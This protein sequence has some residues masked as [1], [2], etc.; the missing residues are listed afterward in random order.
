MVETSRPRDRSDFRVAIFCALPREADAVFLLFDHFWDE[1]ESSYGRAEGDPNHYTN[2]RIGQHDVVLAHL[3]GMGTQ[4]AAAAAASLRTSYT[5]LKLLCLV[6][7]CG[8]VPKIDGVDAFLGDVVISK[9]IIQYDYGRQ[10]PGRFA[11]KETTEDSLGRLNKDIRGLL[12][13]FETDREKALMEDKAAKYL[14]DMQNRKKQSGPRRLNG[15]RKYRNPGLGKDRLYKTDYIHKHHKEC[16]ECRQGPCEVATQ[17]SCSDLGCR[18]SKLVSRS[19]PSD[20]ND[21]NYKPAIFIGRVGSGSTVMKSGEDR[22]RIAKEHGII[23]FEME[24][25]GVWDEA[26]CLI[27]KGICDYADSHKDKRWQDFAAATAASVMKAILDRYAASD[28]FRLSSSPLS[29]RESPHCHTIPYIRNHDVVKRQLEVE[30]LLQLLSNS[31]AY[32]VAALWGLGGSGKTHIALEY[33]YQRW[34]ARDCSIFWVHADTEATFVRDYKTVARKL[35]LD[36]LDND[37]N[38]LEAVR[39]RIESLEN[40]LLVIDNAD[41]ITVFLPGQ[42]NEMTTNLLRYIPQAAGKS[43]TVLWTSRDERIV[44]IAGPDRAVEIS[45]MTEA[46]A[47]K[48]L[49]KKWNKDSGTKRNKKIAKLLEE[50]GCLALA[51]SQAGA[52]MRRTQTGVDEYLS[53]LSKDK[54]RWIL[55]KASETAESQRTPGVPNSVL[56]TWH[57]S[58]E[59][60]QKENHLAYH[61][62]NVLAYVNNQNISTRMMA[63]F[64]KSY[65]ESLPVDYKKK[66]LENDPVV[67]DD[68]D[69]DGQDI[70]I[71][72]ALARLKEYSF[73]QTHWDGKK[74][75]SYKM[76]KLVQ[77]A[78]RFGLSAGLMLDELRSGTSNKG[79]Q[80]YAAIAL[81]VMLRLF[82]GNKSGM[83]QQSEKYFDHAIRAAEWAEIS[84]VPICAARLLERLCDFIWCR[85]HGLQARRL[86]MLEK[87]LG[88]YRQAFGERDTYTLQ[89]MCLLAEGHFYHGAKE[90]GKDMTDQVYTLQQEVFG[91]TSRETV[92]TLLLKAKILSK[93]RRSEE[94][95]QLL[96]QA[97]D[98]CR[99]GGKENSYAAAMILQRRAQLSKNKGDYWKAAD[100]A[101]S[102]L[103]IYKKKLAGETTRAITCMGILVEAYTQI[104]RYGEAVS[105]GETALDMVKAKWGSKHM[106]TN[107]IMHKLALSYFQLG[108]YA[109]AEALAKEAV[110]LAQD[111][112]G[113]P[114]HMMRQSKR[115]LAEMPECIERQENGEPRQQQLSDQFAAGLK[116]LD[117][118]YEPEP[119]SSSS[120]VVTKALASVNV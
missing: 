85:S 12:A 97:M 32:Q 63:E 21:D 114:R 31:T 80:Y 62:L 38:I 83:W 15:G 73:I 108:Q 94:A 33:A 8:G 87:S 120:T 89:A 58:I 79:E 118:E 37:E 99:D 110:Q 26:P 75:K 111:I 81:K 28:R 40:W 16:K 53:M 2:G 72:T 116:R 113:I 115:L 105:V 23:A 109:K 77:D 78:A 25:A 119:G 1:G 112:P 46:E 104:G 29:F 82:P 93:E 86:E 117:A 47:R 90:V 51:I 43:G 13:S 71:L 27:V 74:E 91:N 39:D 107:H 34:D 10:Y 60:I 3:P 11:V 59:R 68:D 100:L 64:A 70:E 9:S 101:S 30:K 48:L 55:F 22:D 69:S 36:D 6:G 61:I 106:N 95:D 41:D 76:H 19:R 35:G 102:G 92:R 50:L 56:G 44:E 45:R 65:G 24:G 66:D 14:Q 17:A 7:I 42:S 88:I 67:A 103:E 57:I 49:Y 18:T 96:A 98:H 5:E 4:N 52:F 84:A 54:H 20:R